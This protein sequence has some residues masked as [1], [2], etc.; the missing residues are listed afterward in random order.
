MTPGIK[1]QMREVERIWNEF[2]AAVHEQADVDVAAGFLAPSVTVLNRPVMTGGADADEVRSYLT[3]VAGSLPAELTREKISRTVDTRR[4]VDES[5]WTFVHD[6]ELPWLL[7]GVPASG[8][9]V[10]VVSVSVVAVREGKI[11]AVRTLWDDAELR[12]QV[13]A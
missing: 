5:R 7:P 13:T 2:W 3:G 11:T 8:R 6:R 10:D 12:R 4:V 9:S 1:M